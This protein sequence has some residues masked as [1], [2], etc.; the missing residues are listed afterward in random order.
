MRKRLL[1][2][3][4]FESI[5]AHVLSN[6]GR[7]ELRSRYI[8]IRSINN[9]SSLSFG[10]FI[11][12]IADEKKKYEYKLKNKNL[13]SENL[14]ANYSEEEEE[15]ELEEEIDSTTA[16]NELE[17]Q[18][19][20]NEIILNEKFMDIKEI[21]Q[22]IEKSTIENRIDEDFYINIYEFAKNELIRTSLLLGIDAE[23]VEPKLDIFLFE[24]PLRL[25]FM[26]YSNENPDIFWRKAYSYQKEWE[27]ISD[28]TLRYSCSFVTETMF[29]RTFSK[30][31]YIQNKRMTNFSSSVM[32]AR[33]QLHESSITIKKKKMKNS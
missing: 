7:S 18:I 30:Q 24:E 21:K 17:R 22:K 31:N 33:L 8:G 5:T 14:I 20:D 10:P 9:P 2:N 25:G 1:K 16:E 29:E 26:K 32:K 19:N 11:Y 4:Y 23:D 15:E 13:N 28:L 6:N 3:V 27:I 12:T